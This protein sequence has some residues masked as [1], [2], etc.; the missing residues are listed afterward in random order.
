MCSITLIFSS[1]IS[2]NFSLFS[3]FFYFF[4][5]KDLKFI[6]FIYLIIVSIVLSLPMLYYIFV[7]DINFMTAGRTPGIEGNSVD[8]SFNLSNKFLIISTIFFFHLFPII[9]VLTDYKKFI[10]LIKNNL[11]YILPTYLVLIYFFNYQTY[12]TGG[13]IFFQLSQILFDNNILFF[14]ISFFTIV[15]LYYFASLNKIN[16]SLILIIVFSNI[17]YTIYNYS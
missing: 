1:Y 14:L 15:Y 17:Q 2:P 6:N 4:F 10:Y 9:Y 16:L 12:F 7:L 5:L 11:I 8:F 3:I 13:G